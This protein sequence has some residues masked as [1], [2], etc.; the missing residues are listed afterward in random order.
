LSTPIPAHP[1]EP[2]APHGPISLITG[3]AGFIGSHLAEHLHG[4][5]QRLILVDDLSTGRAENVAHLLGPDCLLRR[6]SI[7]RY[8]DEHL[9]ELDEV[10]TVYHLAATVGVR[11]VVEDPLG[12]IENNLS[13][14]QRLLAAVA[15]RGTPVL[16]ASSSEVYG[17]NPNVP[18]GE[19]H[20]LLFGPI[21]SPRWAYGMSK[22]MLEHAALAHHLQ[23][24]L[25]AVVVRLFNTIG[26]RQV[27]R[28]GMVVPN[29]VS[30]AVA[31]G[32]LTIHGDGQQSR[33]FCDVRDTVR[34]MAELMRAPQ[35]HAGRPYN[36]GA[37][38][39]IT[40]EALAQTVIDLAAGGSK[41]FVPYERAYDDRFEDMRRRV[42]SLER[43]RDAIGFEPRYQLE[44]TLTELIAAEQARQRS[45]TE[46]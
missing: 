27:G 6:I 23:R 45:N 5:G 43:L 46:A 2:L 44:Q 35:R 39:E 22:A 8:L 20:D 17:R 7:G 37:Q 40:I 26:P 21:S 3:G 30:A 29:F 18:L 4:L 24:G 34:A 25:P 19:E 13:Q 12:M 36:V 42:P 33:A 28:Y 15:E 10:S 31:R 38:R 41:R 11:L 32:E 16:L 1:P 9:S 14:S